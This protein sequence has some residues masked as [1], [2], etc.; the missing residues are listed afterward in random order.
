MS[1]DRSVKSPLSR[2]CQQRLRSGWHSFSSSEEKCLRLISKSL[3]PFLFFFSLPLLSPTHFNFHTTH[4][5][6]GIPFPANKIETQSLNQSHIQSPSIRHRRQLL[7]HG[8]SHNTTSVL[9]TQ[10]G[11]YR[12]RFTADFFFLVTYYFARQILQLLLLTR[13]FQNLR[14]T[15]KSHR[16]SR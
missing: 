14:Q 6:E 2:R 5:Y 15:Y 8:E 13:Y 11:F 9:Q 16:S 1:Y 3:Y 10:S 12:G 7:R 4:T